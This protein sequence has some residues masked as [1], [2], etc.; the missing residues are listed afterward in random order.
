MNEFEDVAL[1]R[2]VW[3]LDDGNDTMSA[4]ERSAYRADADKFLQ[5]LRR[6]ADL[7]W[8][9]EDHAAFI[10]PDRAPDSWDWWT[11]RRGR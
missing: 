2:Q 4:E 9:R 5:V 8:T 3:R 1:L 7:E 10:D 6:M 11:P